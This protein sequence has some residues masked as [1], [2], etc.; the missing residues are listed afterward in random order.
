MGEVRGIA[1]ASLRKYV[2][3]T[4][5]EEGLSKVLD[6]LSEEERG[7]MTGKLEVMQWYPAKAMIDFLKAADKICG[8]GDYKLCYLA[9]KQDAEDVFGGLYKM[10]LEMGKPLTIVRKAPLAWRLINSTGDIQLEKLGENYVIGRIV[11]FEDQ[12]KV[13][14]WHLV[15]YFE[16][17]L[18]L[19]GAK[20]GQVKEL[21]CRSD[22]ADCCEFEVRWE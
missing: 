19:T 17:V 15:G 7:V 11:E 13:H 21:K 12:D 14:C 18:E 16:K 2:R 20:N 8:N 1:L 9:G 6:A 5:G 3:N 22:G 10:F 4:Y